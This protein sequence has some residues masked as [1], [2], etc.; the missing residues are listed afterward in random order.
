[1]QPYRTAGNA[2]QK[3]AAT[4]EL[5]VS[6]LINGVH[7][8]HR[9]VSPA[10]RLTSKRVRIPVPRS[11]RPISQPLD[12]YRNEVNAITRWSHIFFRLLRFRGAQWWCE[13]HK[14]EKASRRDCVWINVAKT[15]QAYLLSN[16]GVSRQVSGIRWA[17]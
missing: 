9:R 16:V 6:Q 13:L 14:A 17:R 11:R 8:I 1:M 15:F 12:N 7:G 3:I 4:L 5:T 10:R 2:K